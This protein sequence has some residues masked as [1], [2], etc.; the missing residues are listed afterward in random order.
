MTLFGTLSYDRMIPF[1]T[2]FDQRRTISGAF[3]MVIFVVL[4]KALSCSLPRPVFLIEAFA[5][6]VQPIRIV[7]YRPPR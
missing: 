5:K 4:V 1:V 6:A 7:Q 3:R 2:L